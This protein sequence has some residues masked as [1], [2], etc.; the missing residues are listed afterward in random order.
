[1]NHGMEVD[2]S[3]VFRLK[4]QQRADDLEQS[5][6]NAATAIHA[7]I[8]IPY[9]DYASQIAQGCRLH[10]R[11]K[12]LGMGKADRQDAYRHLPLAARGAFD[13]VVTLLNPADET[14][15]G[16]APRS[17]LFGSTA[18]AF[19]SSCFPR[20]IASPSCLAQVTATTSRCERR[21]S[22]LAKH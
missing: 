18:A 20:V 21:L 11:I 8:N 7:P 2:T 14:I 13:A 5:Q 17:Q 6:T 9:L 1:M 15:H 22:L 19:H 3:A 4:V 12:M 10:G 16:C